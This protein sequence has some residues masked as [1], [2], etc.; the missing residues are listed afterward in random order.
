MVRQKYCYIELTCQV[1]DFCKFFLAAIS[2]PGTRWILSVQ[3]VLVEGP[4]GNHGCHPKNVS[5]GFL[6][7]ILYGSNF[8]RDSSPIKH[9]LNW[10][11]SAKASSTIMEL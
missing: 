4:K 8:F 2:R 9:N 10:R 6:L 1:L 3:S 5:L 7:A 11:S